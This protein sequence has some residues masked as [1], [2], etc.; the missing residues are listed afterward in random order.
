MEDLLVDVVV[1][2]EEVVGREGA[3]RKAV[4][5]DVEVGLA[6]GLEAAGVDADLLGAV[7]AVEQVE[8][9]VVE[10]AE[11]VA[12]GE[13]AGAQ[14]VVAREDLEVLAARHQQLDDLVELDCVRTSTGLLRLLL[15]LGEDEVVADLGAVLHVLAGRALVA[16]QAD[17]EAVHEVV[18]VRHVDLAV[19][20]LHPDQL[21]H[22]LIAPRAQDLVRRVHLRVQDPEEDEACA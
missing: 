13:P 16:H 10:L 8:P 6:L 7:V 2:E 3:L 12:H 18:A 21:V 11:L 22:H 4:A 5:A 15:H 19:L 1:H 14:V 9:V 20:Q 17:L